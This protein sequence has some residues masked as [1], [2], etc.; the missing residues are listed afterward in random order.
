[1]FVANLEIIETRKNPPASPPPFTKG[2]TLQ[3]PLIKVE[4]MC[5][6]SSFYKGG[7]AIENLK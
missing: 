2:D 7:Q 6:K 5:I 4:K 3:L 1:M